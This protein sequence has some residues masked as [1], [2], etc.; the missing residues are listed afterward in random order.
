MNCPATV[1]TQRVPDVLTRT[2]DMM[3]VSAGIGADDRKTPE[4]RSP[5]L[6]YHLA[7]EV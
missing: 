4:K 5:H 1:K 2:H 6:Y 7:R 3:S